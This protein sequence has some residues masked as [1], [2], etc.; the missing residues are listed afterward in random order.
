MAKTTNLQIATEIVRAAKDKA[1][2][3]EGIQNKLS[4]SRANAF[5]YYTKASKAIG[6]VTTTTKAATIKAVKNAVTETS[7]AKA[8]AKVA[9]IDKVIEGL[10]KSGTKVASPF[11]GLA[12]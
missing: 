2:A 12:A 4:V 8:A 9:E 11:A 3:L 10:K 6:G 5:V 1:Q 7:S